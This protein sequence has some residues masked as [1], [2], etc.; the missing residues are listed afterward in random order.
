[1]SVLTSFP[2]GSGMIYNILLV[3]DPESFGGRKKDILED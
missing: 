3:K 1:M 2:P